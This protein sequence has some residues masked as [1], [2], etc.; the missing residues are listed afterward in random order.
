NA[1]LAKK[2]DGAIIRRDRMEAFSRQFV[3]V[4][5]ALDAGLVCWCVAPMRAESRLI[6]I[7]YLGSRRD[8]AFSERDLELVRQVAGI[9]AQS[10]ENALAH[11]AVQREKNNLQLLLEI[12]RILVPRLDT[13]KLFAEIANCV[14]RVMNPEYAQL[15]LYDEDVGGIR[16]HRLD[17]PAGSK[18]GE[19]LNYS[20]EVS[21]GEEHGKFLTVAELK[22]IAAESRKRLLEEGFL[23]ICSFP[24]ISASGGLG[25][26][27]VAS[28][29]ENAFTA[30]ETELM[31]R[32]TSQIATA[33]DNAR[34]YE[35][36]ASLKDKLAKEK[37]YLEQEIREVFNFEQIVGRSHA[38]S[39]VLDQVKTVAT[40]DASVLILGETGTGKELVARALHRLSPRA[41]ANFVKLNCAAIPTG[42]LESELF[43]H[44][45]GAFTGAV[46]Q[47]VGRLELADKGT[48]FLD[49][50]GEIP[51]E[52]QPKLLR[53]LQ[54]QE[55]ERLGGNRT[56]KVNVR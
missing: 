46:S 39:Q 54:D 50:V 8:D 22:P 37:I 27:E 29:K 52:L 12:S 33:I 30:A 20:S 10:V 45:K 2:P 19:P 9:V 56:I 24:L 32:V 44:E 55:F 7:I 49:E 38:V 4:K 1:I 35:E 48:L 53:V 41:K 31:K 34:A 51:L 17:F 13:K 18:V 36:V 25:T 43:G 26:L 42:L 23:T 14:R 16:I 11:D 40:S 3:I 21:F 28:R 15:A 6:G 47:K 5:R